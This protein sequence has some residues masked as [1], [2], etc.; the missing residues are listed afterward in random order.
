MRL[1]WHRNRE[2]NVGLA[3]LFLPETASQLPSWVALSLSAGIVEEYVYRGV[4][5]AAI[6][7]LTAK[8]YS[9]ALICGAAFG[10]AHL[11][12]GLR[13]G[14]WTMLVGLILQGF[15]FWTGSLYLSMA[16]HAV[17]DLILGTTAVR[18]LTN[19]VVALPTT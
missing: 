4:V 11:G 8:S 19:T 17:Y 18:M 10:A 1:S 5:Y 13:S 15:V 6:F 9:A 12:R 7:S 16:I 3:R 14:V 2:E